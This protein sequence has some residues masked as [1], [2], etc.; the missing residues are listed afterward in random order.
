MIYIYND[1][2]GTHT[3]S[4]AAAYHL[5]TL[6]TNRTLTTEEILNVQY[7]NKLKKKDLGKLIF[8]GLDEDGNEVYTIGRKN[9]KY[10]VPAMQQMASI[11]QSKNK[12][13]EKIVF[14]NT[15]PTVPFVMS[16][17]GFFA[18]GLNISSLGEPLLIIGAKK[19]CQLINQ[20]V[21]ETKNQG[22]YTK[23]NTTILE[24]YN[25]KP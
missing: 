11:L 19:C 22:Y 15:S 1:F 2:G 10:A 3:T 4:L 12:N 20:L 9:N 16:I 13:C 7:F 24:N 5:N 18:R 8:H 25:F 6:P 17:G 14:S 21:Q 23:S